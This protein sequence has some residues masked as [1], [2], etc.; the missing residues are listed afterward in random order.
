MVC[1]LDALSD[2]DMVVSLWRRMMPTNASKARPISD[3]VSGSG[4]NSGPTMCAAIRGLLIPGCANKFANVS[5]ENGWKPGR[6]KAG[7]Y[8]PVAITIGAVQAVSDVGSGKPIGVM[9]K[10]PGV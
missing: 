9:P 4:K 10:L 3:T 8:V 1:F 5:A 6:P 2:F 7:L